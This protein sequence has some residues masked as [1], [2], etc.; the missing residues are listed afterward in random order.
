MIAVLLDCVIVKHVALTINQFNN[1][2]I[3]LIH[4]IVEVRV[5]LP[6]LWLRLAL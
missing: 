1:Q 5:A 3:F 6:E 4:I 2:T